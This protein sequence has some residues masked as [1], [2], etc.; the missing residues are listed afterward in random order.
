MTLMVVTSDQ[1]RELRLSLGETM[2][3]FGERLGVS[4]S[5]VSLWESGQRH[6]KF[7]TLM[8]I[9]QIKRPKDKAKAALA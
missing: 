4:E 3:A 1:I 9:N 5:T 8:K 6:P 7:A 2:A